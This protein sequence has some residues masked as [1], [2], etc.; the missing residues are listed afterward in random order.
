[1]RTKR[2]NRYYCD[3]C[4]KSGCNAAAMK[5]HEKHCTMNPNRYCRMCDNLGENQNCIVDLISVL[6]KPEEVPN[7][8]GFNQEVTDRKEKAID[9]LRDATNGCPICMFSALRQAGLNPFEMGFHLDQELR[10]SWNQIN[11][12]R[13]KEYQT[14]EPLY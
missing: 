10:E 1:M 11:D 5:K 7:N 3:F 12:E 13:W 14:A 2:V 8:V 9:D 6:P 4:K